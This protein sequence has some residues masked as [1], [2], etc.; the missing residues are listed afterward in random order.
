MHLFYS[1]KTNN[2]YAIYK[3]YYL[4]LVKNTNQIILVS[5]SMIITLFSPLAYILSVGKLVIL[6]CSNSLAVASILAITMSSRFSKDSANCY[7]NSYRERVVISHSN[8][9]E[10]SQKIFVIILTHTFFTFT[11]TF[12]LRGYNF[13]QVHCQ[14]L[15]ANLKLTNRKKC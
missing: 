2:N 12:I 11:K 13:K 3:H 4:D 5:R 7:K 10:L 15:T 8:V 1:V 6:V 9:G 14:N